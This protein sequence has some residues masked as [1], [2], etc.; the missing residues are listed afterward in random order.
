MSYN[1]NMQFLTGE[2]NNVDNR[3]SNAEGFEMA[4]GFEYATGN[5]PAKLTPA[6][7]YIFTIKNN[8]TSAVTNLA[9]FRG[10]KNANRVGNGLPTGVV[11]NWLGSNYDYAQFI[12][13][14]IN[15]PFVVGRTIFTSTTAQIG[16]LNIEINNYSA[17][18]RR[19]TEPWD[20]V[21]STFQQISTQLESDYAFTING[22][23]ELV[24]SEL[25]ASVELTVRMY[26]AKV[27]NSSDALD[28]STIKNTYIAPTSQVKQQ[29]QI[30]P[31]KM[32]TL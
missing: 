8:N 9:I 3:W 14:S 17:Q 4:Q 10:I 22:N 23:T 12:T 27:I 18:G 30:A 15:S 2:A 26:A 19:T 31:S 25:D 11:I 1:K 5:A 28:N 16:K 24:I 7:P 13:E 32:M 29:L 6:V 21:I 20:L